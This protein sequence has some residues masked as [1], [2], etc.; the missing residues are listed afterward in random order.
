MNASITSGIT[1]EH[2][3]ITP[4][5][6]RNLL[7]YN[8]HNRNHRPKSVAAYMRDM[9]SGKW[10]F[11]GDAI[12]RAKDG[13]ILD[14]AH[15]LMACSQSN[16][17]IEAIL[18]SGLASES[19]D[20]MDSG[21]R[22]SF[23]DALKLSGETDSNNLAALTV[24]IA[25]YEK[26]GARSAFLRQGGFTLAELMDTFRAHP[27]LP[28]TNKETRSIY[29]SIRISKAT[30]GLLF[31]MFSRIDRADCKAFFTSLRTGEGLK[32]GDPI[33]ALRNILVKSIG[34]RDKTPDVV[35]A[36]LV[37]KAWNKYRVGDSVSNLSYRSGGAS[38]EPFPEAV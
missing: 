25:S 15:R 6:A 31:M 30:F 33:L 19:Q 13:T 3:I 26:Y 9:E 23:S 2:K 21:V 34:A 29:T 17:P 12:R 38:P 8:T 4:D 1:V 20:T 5:E 35:T 32:P 28:E 14:G 11:N 18:V 22:R 36:A 37:I 27:E 10:R 24:R 16:I 7:E